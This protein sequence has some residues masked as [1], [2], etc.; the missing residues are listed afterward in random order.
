MYQAL[1]TV[2]L[3]GLILIPPTYPITEYD[4][5]SLKIDFYTCLYLII[6]PILDCNG[7]SM[8]T[9]LLLNIL[10]MEGHC[11]KYNQNRYLHV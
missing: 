8:H 4:L 10:V 2:Y 3:V 5:D 1:G 6:A 9:R 7:I 11:S